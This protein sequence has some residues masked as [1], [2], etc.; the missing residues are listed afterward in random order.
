MNLM[1]LRYVVE[2]E[3]TGS[4]TRAAKN[5]FMGQPNLSKAVKELENEIGIT[6][7]KRTVRG[8]EPTEKGA[9]FLNYARAILSQIDELEALYKPQKDQGFHM[10]ISVPRG[11]TWP[12]VFSGFFRH[13]DPQRKMD[14]SVKETV[15]QQTIEDVI[16]RKSD[17]G[18]IRFLVSRRDGVLQELEQHRLEHEVLSQRHLCILTAE[19][20]KLGQLS[21]AVLSEQKD[22]IQLIYGDIPWFEEENLGTKRMTVFDRGTLEDLL[23]GMDGSYHL[24]FPVP[25]QN[26]EHSGLVEI[27]LEP[28]GPLVAEAVIYPKQQLLCPCAVQFLNY[29][30]HYSSGMML[31]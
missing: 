28:E 22:Q 1:H 20:G 16:S 21:H 6:L 11:S 13:L 29:L 3:R 31:L 9:E 12:K 5:L 4:I 25:E 30:R 14:F 7:F 19:K 23:L 26:L 17:L 10:K 8:A 27:P 18:I 15:T 24:A 2:V